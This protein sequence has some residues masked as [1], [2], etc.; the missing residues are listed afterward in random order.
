MSFIDGFLLP[1][2]KN[3]LPTCRDAI[4][5]AG[6]IWREHGALD[7]H[8]FVADDVKPATFVSLPWEVRPARGKTVVFVR[9][10]YKSRAH[11]NRVNAR[12]MK[13]PR[14]ADMM[15]GACRQ[16]LFDCQFRK[17]D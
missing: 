8:E 15:F 5:K 7:Y 13:D 11:Y 16:L 6:K 3:R 1:V 17:S 4:R 9:I 12:A 14:L 10:L 2:P